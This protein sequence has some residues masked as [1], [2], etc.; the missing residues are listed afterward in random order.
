MARLGAGLSYRWVKPLEEDEAQ[1]NIR[2][3]NGVEY[4]DVLN[5]M[6]GEMIDGTTSL[7]ALKACVSDW[8]GVE[9][10]KGSTVE[11]NPLLISELSAKM[12]NRLGRLMMR[13]SDFTEIDSK[14]SASQ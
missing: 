2:P 1:F 11:Y 6:D 5:G 13:I 9:D 10:D 7:K 4:L 8:K 12:L 14:N 3:L